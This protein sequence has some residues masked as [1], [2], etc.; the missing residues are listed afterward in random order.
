MKK[1]IVSLFLCVVM[2]FSLLG[3]TA[4]AEGKVKFEAQNVKT[5]LATGATVKVAVN[6]TENPGLMSGSYCVKWDKTALE[7]TAVEFLAKDYPDASS[8]A[9]TENNGEYWVSFGIDTATES[10]TFTGKAFDLTFKVL[11]GAEAKTYAITLAVED[12]GLANADADLVAADV[13]AGSIT[14]TAKPVAVTGVT[15]NP[16]SLSLEEGA[17]AKLTATVNPDNATDKTVTWTV[18]PEGIVTVA[19]DGT[20]TA[21]K[22][23]KATITATAGGKKA[24]CAVT[25]TEKTCDHADKEYHAAVDATCTEA[26]NVEYWSCKNCSALFTK[27]EAG[28]FVATANV[29]IPALGHKSTGENVAT[30]QHK[31]KCDVCSV[32]YGEV[33]AHKLTKV[34]AKEP[35]CKDTGNTEYWVCDNCGT[36]FADAKGTKEVTLDDVTLPVDENAHDYEWVSESEGAIDSKIYVNTY[37][38]TVCDAVAYDAYVLFSVDMKVLKDENS[39]REVPKNVAFTVDVVNEEDTTPA[40]FVTDGGDE[41]MEGS[42]THLCGG[43]HATPEAAIAQLKQ[44]LSVSKT[45]KQTTAKKSGWTL[46]DSEYVVSFV[47]DENDDTAYTL[48]IKKNGEDADSVIF[49]NTYCKKTSGAGF[50]DPDNVYGD[51]MDDGKINGSNKG[52]TTKSDGKTV[53]SVKTFDAGI[54]LYV[55]LSILSLTGS[56]VVIGKKKVR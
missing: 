45:M 14:L 4:Y 31:A 13:V 3:V 56:A 10:A 12:D 23:G 54:G 51:L 9:I 20:V 53:N 48:D 27:N 5:E 7:L 39:K 28:E 46:D 2:L 15:L 35:T 18:K 8:P 1:R 42:W 32:E 24:T 26:G 38:C 30:C 52:N 33:L 55:G 29:T 34:A 44:E 22:A 6:I 36:L 40:R 47:F 49:V 11:A 50:K 19:E 16:T 37:K 41:E 43:F 17:S 25:V 21:V